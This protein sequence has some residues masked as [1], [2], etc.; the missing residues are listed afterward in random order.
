MAKFHLPTLEQ[1]Q[2]KIW[3]EKK[4][5]EQL[6]NRKENPRG[7]FVFFEGPPTANNKPGIHH[8]LTRAYKDVVLRYRSMRG[9]KQEHSALDACHL[10]ERNFRP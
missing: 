1:D 7:N 10:G 2:L 3:D 5:F 8:Q 9:Y 6:L 4:V